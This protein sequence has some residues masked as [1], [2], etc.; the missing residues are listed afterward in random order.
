MMTPARSDDLHH[1]LVERVARRVEGR[2]VSRAAIDAAV[3]SV[4][5]ALDRASSV[6]PAAEGVL[7]AAVTTR[8][9]PDLASRLRGALARA[10]VEVGPIGI[11]ASGFH[12]VATLRLP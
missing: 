4:L 12:H 10:G 5:G 9:M 1:T 3:G 2:G 6:R 8:S 7:V 11:A